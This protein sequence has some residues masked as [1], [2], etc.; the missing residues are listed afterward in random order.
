MEKFANCTILSPLSNEP[1]L[2]KLVL[3]IIIES[4]N[5]YDDYPYKR[6]SIKG[7]HKISFEGNMNGLL[8]TCQCCSGST[9]PE[10][11]TRGTGLSTLGDRQP[12]SSSVTSLIL[13]PLDSMT[14]LVLDSVNLMILV[15]SPVDLIKEKQVQLLRLGL[16]MTSAVWQVLKPV[17][18]R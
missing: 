15:L 2:T 9:C 1:Y 3:N 4:I 8:V 7:N 17:T 18:G 13:D 12:D 16:P 5:P 6:I 10:W 14:Q 11:R